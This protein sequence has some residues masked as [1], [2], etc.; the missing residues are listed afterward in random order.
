MVEIE[1]AA[2]RERRR[3]QVAEL[4]DA[5]RHVADREVIGLRALLDFIPRERRGHGRARCWPGR[6]RGCQS[7]APG[8]LVV[9]DEYATCRPLRDTIFRSNEAGA[10]ARHFLR[11]SLCK[12]PH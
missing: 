4:C 5:S 1:P 10:Q 9:V 7:A 6:I 12:T 3:P 8:I 11:E 2:L